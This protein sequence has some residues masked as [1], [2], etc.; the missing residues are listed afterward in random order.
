MR[1][2]TEEQVIEY[3]ELEKYPKKD[4]SYLYLLNLPIR[5]M[6]LDQMN[7][8]KNEIEK[9]KKNIQTLQEKSNKDLWI[10]DLN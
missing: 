5:T 4:N 7:K 3:L 10:D 8:L 1:K 2:Q 6:T 9:I